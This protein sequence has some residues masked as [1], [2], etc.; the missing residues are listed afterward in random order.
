MYYDDKY[1][2]KLGKGADPLSKARKWLKGRS[3]RERFLMGCAGAALVC[4]HAII[5]HRTIDVCSR[6]MCHELELLSTTC[7]AAHIP[8]MA[9]DRRS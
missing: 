2:E 8:P 3:G 9:C 1:S 7:D 5:E 6:S 4:A